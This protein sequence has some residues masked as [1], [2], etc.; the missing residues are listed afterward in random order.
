MKFIFPAIIYIVAFAAHLVFIYMF[1]DAK[2]YSNWLGTLN[3]FGGKPLPGTG[4][5]LSTLYF[6][7]LYPLI[8]SLFLLY[9]LIVRRKILAPLLFML[10]IALLWSIYFYGP[11]VALGKIV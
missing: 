4:L 9:S 3:S 11:I 1:N 10:T 8:T 5:L 2:T 7:W 6:W